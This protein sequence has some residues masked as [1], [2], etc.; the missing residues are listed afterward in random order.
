[1][2]ESSSDD[3]GTGILIALGMT[4][5]LSLAWAYIIKDQADM[6]TWGAL[7]VAGVTGLVAGSYSNNSQSVAVVCALAAPLGTYLGTLLG[8]CLIAVAPYGGDFSDAWHLFT[9]ETGDVAHVFKTE[10][11]DHD[12]LFLFLSAPVGYGAAMLEN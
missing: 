12:W 4:A 6:M 5:G 2:S 8:L 7:L 3:E 11:Q 10:A 9:S 1:M